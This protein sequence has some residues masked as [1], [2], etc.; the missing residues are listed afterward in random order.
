MQLLEDGDLERG[1]SLQ[2]RVERFPGRHGRCRQQLRPG[3]DQVAGDSLGVFDFERDP[4]PRT[5]A[6]ADLYIVDHVHLSGIGQ[7]QRGA[8]DV[9]DRDLL[10]VFAMD[11][12]FFGRA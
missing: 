6:P 7:L 5:D 9:E 8:A 12:E 4:E 1:G 2:P 10:A 3:L 11:G